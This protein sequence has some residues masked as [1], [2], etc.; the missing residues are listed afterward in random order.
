MPQVTRCPHCSKSYRTVG[1]FST[2]LTC[3]HKDAAGS[4]LVS[5]DKFI[6]RNCRSFRPGRN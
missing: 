6:A 5:S 1:S 4:A 3:D 2:H